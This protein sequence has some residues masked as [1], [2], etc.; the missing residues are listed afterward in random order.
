M[1]GNEPWN[2]H[3]KNIKSSAS[4]S[5]WDGETSLGDK[6]RNH[7]HQ[8]NSIAQSW[9]FIA[10]VVI[11]SE[12]S[13]KIANSELRVIK[14]KAN[15]KQKW[16]REHVSAFPFRACSVRFSNDWQISLLGRSWKPESGEIKGSRQPS[17]PP[18]T[19]SALEAES[20]RGCPRWSC[21]TSPYRFPFSQYLQIGER[22]QIIHLISR[23]VE[24]DLRESRVERGWH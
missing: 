20:L 14:S 15:P 17:T 8:E 18:P 22:K 5:S 12:L 7:A 19:P 4:F 9:S 16:R 23:H 10:L 1:E 21:F 6:E 3:S 2:Y 13:L 11:V 24:R